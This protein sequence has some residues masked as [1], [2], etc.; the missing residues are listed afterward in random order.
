MAALGAGS[1]GD[2]GAGITAGT[3]RFL[4]M[5]GTLRSRSSVGTPHHPAIAP[6]TAT[7]GSSAT[8][9]TPAAIRNQGRLRPLSPA[10]SRAARRTVAR[11]HHA[12]AL[13]E[14]AE[15]GPVA[16]RVDQ[17]RDAPASPGG[18]RPGPPR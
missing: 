2:D 8:A 13:G 14:G 15:E 11:A 6:V 7:V 12:L 1:T 17:P 3:G 4:A 9:A 10:T 18:A 16:E 5:K